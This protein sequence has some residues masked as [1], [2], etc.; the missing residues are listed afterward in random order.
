MAPFPITIAE[1]NYP[2]NPETSQLRGLYQRLRSDA[3]TLVRSRAQ[4]VSLVS[5]QQEQIT[6]LQQELAQFSSDMELTLQQK[7]RLNHI[8]DGYA[9]VIDQLEKA[10][11]TLTAAVDGNGWRGAFSFSALM[12]AVRAFSIAWKAAMARSKEIGANTLPEQN[13]VGR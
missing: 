3:S 10:G 6:C 11:D 9:D 2:R 1:P 7:A 5:R 4:Y 12:E 8:L 13:N